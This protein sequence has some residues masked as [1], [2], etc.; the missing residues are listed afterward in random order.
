MG[1][2]SFKVKVEGGAKDA[3]GAHLGIMLNAFGDD[4][5]YGELAFF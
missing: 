4:G 5:V 1:L 2:V 3:E